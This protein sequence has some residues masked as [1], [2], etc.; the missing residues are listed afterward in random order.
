MS[1]RDTLLMTLDLILM[2]L[3][4]VM[5]HSLCGSVGHWSVVT[6]LDPLP[7]LEENNKTANLERL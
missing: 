1:W 3:L 5:G 7:T 6:P 4:W 2:Q